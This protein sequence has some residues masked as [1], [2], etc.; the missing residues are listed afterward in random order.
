MRTILKVMALVLAL[1]CVLV[2]AACGGE[3]LKVIDHTTDR[4]A[5][6]AVEIRGVPGTQRLSAAAVFQL[7][8]EKLCKL[9]WDSSETREQ[10]NGTWLLI[11]KA[12]NATF[13]FVFDGTP[14]APDTKASYL[15][16]DDLTMASSAYITSE[17]TLNTG[18]P[19]CPQQVRD[20]VVEMDGGWVSVCELEGA[21]AQ[22][23]F[24]G[25][26]DDEDAYLVSV[27]FRREA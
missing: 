1:S 23:M 5:D 25:D 6:E 15:T 17:L 4:S 16:V 7:E 9:S 14:E 13:T 11:T 3:D 20:N 26:M 18:L 24:I 19:D 22:L 27:Q 21:H 2:L 10:D 8:Y 12:E